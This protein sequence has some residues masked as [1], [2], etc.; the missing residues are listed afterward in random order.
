MSRN[1][2]RGKDYE[3]GTI[4]TCQ[5]CGENFVFRKRK[6]GKKFC[7]HE[8]YYQNKHQ[9]K[10]IKTCPRCGKKFQHRNK[11]CSHECA[12]PKKTGSCY[13]CSEKLIGR[14]MFGTKR[15]HRFC[16]KDC[17]IVWRREKMTGDT[18]PN[19]NGGKKNATC[20]R[21][22]KV[23]YVFPSRHG[24]YC[25][26]GCAGMDAKRLRGAPRFERKAKKELEDEGYYVM[27]SGGSLGV[28]DV[29]AIN[30]KRVRLIQVKS[31]QVNWDLKYFSKDVGRMKELVVPEICEKELWVWEIRKGWKKN[32]L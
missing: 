12:Q 19:W 28:F 22:G 26:R 30:E 8:C 5:Q 6:T 7:S 27:K 29:I 3:S 25:S 23:F 24:A 13:I 10:S 4:L 1:R 16:S 31:T 17:Q 20:S 15:K 21:C 2:Q 11:Y 18:N 14:P 32:V 9:N